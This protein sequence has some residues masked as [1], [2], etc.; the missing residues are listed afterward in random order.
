[1]KRIIGICTISGVLAGALA[2][3]PIGLIIGGILGLLLDNLEVTKT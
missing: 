1:M 2:F 3:G